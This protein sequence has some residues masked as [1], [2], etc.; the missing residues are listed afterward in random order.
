MSARFPRV[1]RLLVSLDDYIHV[2]MC[3][4]QQHLPFERQDALLF[5]RPQRANDRLKDVGA[6]VVLY[7]RAK[8]AHELAVCVPAPQALHLL[9]EHA[10]LHEVSALG[11]CSCANAGA[12]VRP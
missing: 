2:V 8:L 4:R 10:N 6:P 1:D 7:E 12:S 5:R 3:G 11:Q 9:E